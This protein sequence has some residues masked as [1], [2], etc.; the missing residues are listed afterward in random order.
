[1]KCAEDWVRLNKSKLDGIEVTKAYVSEQKI[2]YEP[3]KV[4]L[5]TDEFY[6]GSERTFVC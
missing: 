5:H 4:T 6:L 1:M 3:Q 2:Q